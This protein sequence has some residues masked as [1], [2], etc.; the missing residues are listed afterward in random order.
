MGYEFLVCIGG[1]DLECWGAGS[2]CTGF[3]GDNLGME[4]CLGNRRERA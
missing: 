1:L 3:G 2:L 4:F